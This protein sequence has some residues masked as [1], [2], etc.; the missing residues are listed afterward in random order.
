MGCKRKCTD[1][2]QPKRPT[3]PRPRRWKSCSCLASPS[4]CAK[5]RRTAAGAADF[6]EEERKA[7]AKEAAAPPSK[8]GMDIDEFGGLEVGD[9]PVA[10]AR[11]QASIDELLQAQTWVLR[12]QV[13]RELSSPVLEKK[14]K[15]SDVNGI[16][17]TTHREWMV[18]RRH[19]TWF[20]GLEYPLE[21]GRCEEE[22]GKVERE[23]WLCGFSP[24]KRTALKAK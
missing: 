7:A 8:E 23:G 9:D 10:D 15:Q 17:W 12:A 1:K 4:T 24:A 5:R 11:T 14:T 2:Q 6:Y 16:F 19:D 3:E 20:L 21:A 18:M 22:A 13:A